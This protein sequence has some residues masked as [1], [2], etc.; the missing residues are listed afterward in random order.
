M[1]TFAALTTVLFLM[2]CEGPAEIGMGFEPPPETEPPVIAFEPEPHDCF[3]TTVI[4]NAL[5]EGPENG[6]IYLGLEDIASQ[7]RTVYAEYDRNANDISEFV[8]RFE[9]DAATGELTRLRREKNFEVEV[10]YEVDERGNRTVEEQDIDVDGTFDVRTTRTYDANDEILTESVDNGANGS[11]DEW[12]VWE[13]D[14]DGRELTR[15]I[16][17]NG[18]DEFDEIW[19]STYDAEGRLLEQT[20]DRNLDTPEI[21]DRSTYVY[22][23]PTGLDHTRTDDE[24]NDGTI[25]AVVVATFDAEDRLLTRTTDEDADDD[26]DRDET[27]TYDADGRITLSS[28]LNAEVLREE[29]WVYDAEGRIT[30]HTQL[31]RAGVDIFVDDTETTTFGGTCP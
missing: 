19:L 28:D 25:D 20:I 26:I 30:L 24:R 10:R 29:T 14:V 16:D 7:W 9:Y 6:Y 22:D 31:I 2:G 4:D 3:G 15:S 18:D 5:M 13:R 8:D 17:D 11:R 21:D 12:T 1:R 23:G 27:Y